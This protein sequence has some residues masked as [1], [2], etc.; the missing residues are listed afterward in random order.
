MEAKRGWRRA[1]FGGLTLETGIVQATLTAVPW[2]I[3][4][5][6]I[7]FLCRFVLKILNSTQV[8]LA[9]GSV[10]YTMMWL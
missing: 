6:L 8:A 7:G 10:G 1:T 3:A 9:N 5:G 4:L 2:Q